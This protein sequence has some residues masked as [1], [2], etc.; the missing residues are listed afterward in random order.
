MDALADLKAGDLTIEVEKGSMPIRLMWLGKSND[1][2]PS[3]ILQ[4]Y[5]ATALDAASAQRTGLEL[6]FEKLEHFNSSTVTAIIQ[7]V[8]EARQKGVKLTLAFDPSLK[9]QRL[10]F[11]ALR[12][13]VKNDGL[14]EMA[15]VA[16]SKSRP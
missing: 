15:P 4:P 5:F 8:Q 3:K 12:V 13:F 6:H 11:D 14:L 1:R 2:Q 16:E 7:L 9:W 10:S